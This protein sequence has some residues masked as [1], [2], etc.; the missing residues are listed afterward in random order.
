MTMTRYG[1]SRLVRTSSGICVFGWWGRD[2]SNEFLPIV[3]TLWTVGPHILGYSV[4][5]LFAVFL[6][7]TELL[8]AGVYYNTRQVLLYHIIR[9]DI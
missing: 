4:I 3:S 6:N 5:F 9:L 8:I 7:T 1:H 2:T